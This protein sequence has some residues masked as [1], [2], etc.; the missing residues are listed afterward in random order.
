MNW[1]SAASLASGEEDFLAF[2]RAATEDACVT[3][4]LAKYPALRT[5]ALYCCALSLLAV[6]ICW[7]PVLNNL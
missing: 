6:G 1:R 2:S 7:L 5:A 3:E 4:E